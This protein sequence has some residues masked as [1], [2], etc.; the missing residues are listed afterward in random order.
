M[1]LIGIDYGAKRVGIAVSDEQGK[2]A[3]PHQV[4]PN[5]PELVKKIKELCI[6]KKAEALVIGESRDLDGR[7]NEILKE[8]TLLKSTLETVLSVPV[9]LEPEY[10]TSAEAERVQGKNDM[11]DASAAALILKRYLEHHTSNGNH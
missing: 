8:I 2:F 1:R 9:Y 3:L 4:W 10:F 11:H 5:S 6:E 7:P